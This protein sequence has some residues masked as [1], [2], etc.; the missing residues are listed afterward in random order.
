MILLADQRLRV[1]F[2]QRQLNLILFVVV[3]VEDVV[4][5]ISDAQHP[6]VLEGLKQSQSLIE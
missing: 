5:S 4:Y 1:Y 6:C 2:L 3:F